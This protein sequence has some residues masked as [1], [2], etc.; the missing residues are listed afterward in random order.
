MGYTREKGS[1]TVV[2]ISAVALGVLTI[3]GWILWG[4]S[5]KN[6]EIE[7]PYSVK[8]ETTHF[9]KPDWKSAE[10]A[11]CSAFVATKKVLGGNGSDMIPMIHELLQ[12]DITIY[13]F[14]PLS[15]LATGMGIQHEDAIHAIG[16]AYNIRTR[17]ANIWN[18]ASYNGNDHDKAMNNDKTRMLSLA[19]EVMMNPEWRHSYLSVVVPWL[20]GELKNN[21]AK[22][23]KGDDVWKTVE[24]SKAMKKWC[25]SRHVPF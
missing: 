17:E 21:G 15:S 20:D 4:H 13:P 23:H 9:I 5:W 24:Q 12:I 2:T 25:Q 14:K 3:V 18:S 19:A 8:T 16:N 10:W 11:I 6:G 7:Q 1:Q 22:R